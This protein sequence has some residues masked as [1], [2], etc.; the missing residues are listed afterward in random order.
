[1]TAPILLL[2]VDGVVA[3]LGEGSEPAFEI[4][5]A[6]FPIIISEGT[7]ARLQ[8]LSEQFQ[9]IWATS[10]EREAADQLAPILKLGELPFIRFGSD[11]ATA[12]G[13]YKL[14]AVQRFIRDRPAAWVDD[15]LGDDV[16]DWA[17]HRETP[18]LLVRCDPRTGLLDH[19]VEQL[20]AFAHSLEER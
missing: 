14:P 17:E 2:D 12:D 13:N 20:L 16:S 19:H 10:W 7:P 6:G 8:R 15:D 1:M 3:L 18:T 11:L 5:V 9:L 4:V